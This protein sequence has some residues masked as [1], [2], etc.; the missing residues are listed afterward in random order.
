[1][2]PDKAA[3]ATMIVLI[4][5]PIAI[6]FL[7]PQLVDAD[8]VGG[9]LFGLVLIF[10]QLALIVW[11][12]DRVGMFLSMRRRQNTKPHRAPLPAHEVSPPAPWSVAK[13]HDLRGSFTLYLDDGGPNTW[14]E[15]VGY[16]PQRA[17]PKDVRRYFDVLTI[18]LDEPRYLG[19]GSAMIDELQL[20]LV[21][22][23]LNYRREAEF[24][25]EWPVSAIAD[26][27]HCYVQERVERERQRNQ[28]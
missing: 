13:R 25:H 23:I 8:T 22:T 14:A 21:K 19:W 24:F 16:A 11:L 9:L 18:V 15:A 4:V 17:D 27:L 3:K 7:A 6:V 20:L 2:D 28:R 1:M 12:P 5:V 10:G 26:R